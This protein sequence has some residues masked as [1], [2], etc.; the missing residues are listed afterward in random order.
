MN[1]LVVL[2]DGGYVKY[3]TRYVARN[4]LRIPHDAPLTELASHTAINATIYDVMA[5]ILRS[6]LGS[7]E[8]N[9]AKISRCIICQDIGN[10]WRTTVPK[11]LIPGTEQAS[12]IAYKGHRRTDDPEELAAIESLNACYKR[13][14]N[15]ICANSGIEQVQSYGIEADDFMIML[16]RQYAEQGDVVI[17]ICKD[18]DILQAL[19]TSESG[20]R[21]LIMQPMKDGAAQF[22]VDHQTKADASSSS[23]FDMSKMP[24]SLA[25]VVNNANV[26]APQ[27]LLFDKIMNGDA[28]DD[29]SPIMS[30]TVNGRT[31]KL[32]RKQLDKITAMLSERN[33]VGYMTWE[34]FYDDEAIKAMLA[35]AHQLVHKQEFAKLPAEWQQ[36][37]YDKFCENRKM[38]FCN[39]QELGDH[40]NAIWLAASEQLHGLTPTIAFPTYEVLAKLNL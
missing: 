9:I 6:K 34:Q 25:N 37:Y 21:V 20:G 4:R 2:L 35:L 17:I 23:I 33:D 19:Y 39:K 12:S 26:V 11:T 15:A 7:I 27:Y 28:S 5:Q 3:M 30:R 10:S 32:T 8:T 14:V 16:S 40:Y 36:F 18:A 1:K 22:Y 13:S 38:V 31:Y 29:I 24:M